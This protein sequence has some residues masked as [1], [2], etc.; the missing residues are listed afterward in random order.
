VVIEGIK[1]MITRGGLIPGARLPIERDLATEFAV[2]RGSLR[3]GVRALVMMGVL[4][5]RQGDGTYVTSLGADLL[6]APLE[7]I[8]DMQTAANSAH[9]QAVRRVLESEAVT[10]AATRITEDQLSMARAVLDDIEDLVDDDSTKHHERVMEADIAFHRIIAQATDNPVLE[11][12]I[13]ALSSRTLR[14]RV[15]RAM[16]ERGVMRVAQT[17]HRSILAELEVHDSDRAR[18]RM[19]NH[20]LG[21]ER[22]IEDKVGAID[23]DGVVP[24]VDEASER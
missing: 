24:Q 21:V 13:S 17:E 6:F 18:I 9:I 4:E 8:V 23:S 2:S 22:F 3:E 11:A 10:L 19:A 20:L 16:S 12:L 15:W 14:A 1:G 5:T 7:L